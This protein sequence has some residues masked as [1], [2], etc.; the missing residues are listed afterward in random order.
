[1]LPSDSK[2]LWPQRGAERQARG[3]SW[4]W[5]D[6]VSPGGV[7][8][9]PVDSRTRRKYRGSTRLKPSCDYLWAGGPVSGSV[10][11]FLHK[12]LRSSQQKP[13]SGSWQETWG[14]L[15]WDPARVTVAEEHA[16][17]SCSACLWR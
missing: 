4:P 15:A 7:P 17:C 11:L 5:A 14:L 3:S 16:P 10:S 9:P 2:G 8:G 13:S 12:H 1:M 6:S